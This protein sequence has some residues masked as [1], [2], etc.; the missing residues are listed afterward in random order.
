MYSHAPIDIQKYVIKFIINE[1]SYSRSF[2]LSM[3]PWLNLL[4]ATAA[5]ILHVTHPRTDLFAFQP[6]NNTASDRHIF[7]YFIWSNKSVNTLDWD[8]SVLVAYQPPYVLTVT[9]LE[10]FVSCRAVRRMAKIHR[11]DLIG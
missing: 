10:E 4:L 1:S 9:D 5:R 11:A 6:G 3:I 8:G 7:Q 2:D